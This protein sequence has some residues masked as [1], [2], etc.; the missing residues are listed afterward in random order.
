MD[1]LALRDAEFKDDSPVKTVERIKSIL[2]SVGIETEESWSESNV[3]YCH[4]LRVRVKGTTF[5]VNGKGLTREFAH[6][7]G[8]GELMERLQLGYIG[9]RDVQKDGHFSVDSVQ[10]VEVSAKKLLED[11][12]Q[13]YAQMAE[14]LRTYCGTELAPDA[15][16]LQFA[17]ANG[18]VPCAPFFNLTT[19][20]P[21]LFP[22]NIRKNVYTTNGC[23]AGNSPEEAIVQAISEVVERYHHIHI[24][25]R[26]LALPDIPDE[27][28]QQFE[29]S[30]SIIRYLREKGFRVLIKDASLG[31]KFPVICACYIDESTGKYHT[32]FGAYPVFEIALARALTET[33]QGRTIDSFT[34]FSDFHIST[35]G[36]FDINRITNE[37]VKGTHEKTTQFF[38]GE[39]VCPFDP[40][41]GIPG[42]NNRELLTACIRMFSEMGHEILVRNACCLGFPTYQIIV[43]G[44]S[45]F[46]IYR[47]DQKQDEFRYLSSATKALR[48]PSAASIEEMMSVVMHLNQMAALNQRVGKKRNFFAAAQLSVDLDKEAGDRMMAAAKSYIW[49][50]LGRN[51]DALKTMGGM[52]PLADRAEQE[53][54]I[55][56]KRYLTLKVNRNTEEHI[57]S[58]LDFFHKKETVQRL[59][60]C[61]AQHGNPF[62][63]FTLHCD[64]SDCGD[65]R[66][67]TACCQKQAESLSSLIAQKTKELDFEAFA[68]SMRALM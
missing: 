16:L 18:N 36:V 25:E 1:T 55:C 32:H 14:H 47:L 6:A 27:Y 28:L 12:P 56:L 59:Y 33:F 29:V 15:M 26:E 64:P 54:W 19:G 46:F 23:S 5:G 7:S 58:V 24:V 31:R 22:N 34:E 41:M 43:P 13:R 66:I 10:T 35:P 68:Q 40:D 52:L 2:A 60:D 57:R 9:S 17:D 63:P 50:A 51:K 65:C 39:P 21:D 48:N 3:P 4:S 45:E 62:E 49:Y 11:N 42:K 30:Y 67:R 38:V 61:L 37:L 44:Y 8:Y 53:Y 20:Q